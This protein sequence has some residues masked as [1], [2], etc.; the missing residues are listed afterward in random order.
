MLAAY[1]AVYNSNCECVGVTIT[2]IINKIV[3]TIL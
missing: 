3:C 2:E 1:F